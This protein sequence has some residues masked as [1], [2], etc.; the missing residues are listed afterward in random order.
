MERTENASMY[1]D[2]KKTN[3]YSSNTKQQLKQQ[4]GHQESKIT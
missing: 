1:C 4:N 3:N 2:S